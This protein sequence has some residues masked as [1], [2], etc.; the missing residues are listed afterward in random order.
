VERAELR[1]R[2]GFMKD[3]Q[4]A[5]NFALIKDRENRIAKKIL[6]AIEKGQT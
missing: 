3:A 5:A 2:A 6:A 4:E 1:Y